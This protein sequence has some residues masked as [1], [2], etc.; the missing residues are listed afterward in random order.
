MHKCITLYRRM[1][2]CNY[3]LKRFPPC[4]LPLVLL[5]PLA[6]LDGVV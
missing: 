5:V 6:D 4:N 1:Q 3:A 2:L